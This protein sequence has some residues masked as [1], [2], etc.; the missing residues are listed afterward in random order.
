MKV[1]KEFLLK[2]RF[3]V[4]L[5]VFVPAWLIILCIIA[6]TSNKE[7]Q[8]KFETAKNNV[9]KLSNPRNSKWVDALKAKQEKLDVR[10]TEIWDRGFKEQNTSLEGGDN[11]VITWPNDTKAPLGTV[12]KDKYFGDEFAKNALDSVNMRR[13]YPRLYRAQMSQ[14]SDIPKPAYL[15][16]GLDRMIRNGTVVINKGT[17][18][19]AEECWYLQEEVCVRRELLQM[20]KNAIDSVG[21]FR[22]N[23]QLKRLETVTETRGAISFQSPDWQLDFVIERSDDKPAEKT[24][25]P[26]PAEA[27][28]GEQKPGEAKPGDAKAEGDKQAEAKPVEKPADKPVEPAQGEKPADGKVKAYLSLRSKL[29]NLRA[30]PASLTDLRFEI[31]QR[32]FSRR[33]A[34]RRLELKLQGPALASLK[35]AEVKDLGIKDRIELVGFNMDEP[36]DVEL[37]L[38]KGDP[39]PQGV[40]QR[41]RLR[42]SLWEMELLFGVNDKGELQL[43][44]TSRLTNIQSARRTLPLFHAEFQ[45]QQGGKN[46]ITIPLQGEPV[47]WHHSVQFKDVGIKAPLAM[48]SLNRGEPLDVQQV[49]SWLNSPVKRVDALE[50]GVRGHSHRT[51]VFKMEPRIKPSEE[52][53]KQATEAAAPAPGGPGGTDDRGGSGPGMMNMGGGPGGPTTQTADSTSFTPVL[54]LDRNRYARVTEPVRR[55]PVGLVLIVDQAYMQEVLAAFSP[56]NSRLRFHQTQVI[57]QHTHGIRP[58]AP[59]GSEP[60]PGTPTE[61]GGPGGFRP[62]GPGGVAGMGAGDNRSAA[63]QPTGVGGGSGKGMGGIGGIGGL[64]PGGPGGFR[65][66]GPGAMGPGGMGPGGMGPGGMSPGMPTG[67]FPGPGGYPGLGGAPTAADPEEDPNLIELQIYGLVSLYERFPPQKAPETT[68]EAPK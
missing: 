53:T 58:P 30:V 31:R 9:T 20:V 33:G 3:W 32:D 17:D 41:E 47:A 5:G 40:V 4:C 55:L 27:K 22:N 56:P 63:G 2:N 23:S 52:E 25:E 61:P 21:H 39:L 57:W 34:W 48:A 13:E 14:L 29:T 19:T 49:M 68:P 15:T 38:D 44:P 66:S 59:P 67:G 60:E 62:G 51:V 43:L 18:P 45:L 12:M 10:K 6:F 11:P 65:P 7:S 35:A 50:L 46:P 64:Q 26:A 24:E 54:H 8:S 37:K 36:I 42:N 16:P 28:P 1:D